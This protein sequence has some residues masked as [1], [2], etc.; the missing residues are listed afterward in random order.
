MNMML[1]ITLV[2]L[3]GF[4]TGVAATTLFTADL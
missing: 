3:A 2:F 1:V 4:A